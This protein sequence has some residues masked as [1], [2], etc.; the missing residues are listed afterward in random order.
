MQRIRILHIITRL[1]VGGPSL[2]VTYLTVGFNEGP[3]ESKLVAGITQDHE[4]DMSFVPENH[5]VQLIQLSNLYNGSGPFGDLKSFWH[6]YWIFKRER[7]DIADLHLL[8]ARFFG[9]LAA[10]LAGVPIVIETF[11]GNLFN[12]YY[13]KLKTL[14]ILAAERLL[15]WLIVDKV[16]AI[17]ESQKEE[18][19]RYRVCPETKIH[20]IPLGLDLSRFVQCS[21]F[22]GELRKELRF[23]EKT[24]LLGTV[25]RLVPIKGLSYLLQAIR[26]VAEITDIDFCL[27]VIGDG[28]LRKE[29]ESKVLA[30]AIENKVR[31]LGWRFDLEKIY[32]DLD[33]V[34]LSSLNEGTSVS[35]IEAMAAGKAV[36]A[37]KVG[38]VPDVVEDGA[39]GLLVP[40]KDPSA[41]ADAL[42]QLLENVDLRRRLGA[43]AR[44]SVYPRYDVSRLIQDMK[45][46][47]VDS[48]GQSD[49]GSVEELIS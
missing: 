23:P 12:E 24:M 14:F 34:V 47:Y 8:K 32:A 5:G 37:T 3:F 18:L 41:L 44:A 43:Q 19:I 13:G 20:V 33:V 2:H 45:K 40:P 42:L 48:L 35:V 6:L 10:K 25:G 22:N 49:S 30:L 38:G 26:R 7:P 17:S 11:H 29:L 31:F 46:F 4:G 21:K 16:I 27:L 28:L 9:G 1:N 39:T 15:G 36:V